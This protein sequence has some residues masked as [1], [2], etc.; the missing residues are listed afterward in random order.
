MDEI[1]RIFYFLRMVY[2][3]VIYEFWEMFNIIKTIRDGRIRKFI[4]GV[5]ILIV[6]ELC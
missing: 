5:N 4:K 1:I 2:R 6:I 3:Y